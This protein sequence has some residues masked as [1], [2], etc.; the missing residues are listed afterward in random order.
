ML[1]SHA[2]RGHHVRLGAAWEDLRAVH[3]YPPAVEQL[4][5]EA[6]TA[7]VLLAATLKFSGKLTLQF[8]GHGQVSLLVAQC[9]DDFCVR[10]VAQHTDD[11]PPWPT[12]LRWLAMGA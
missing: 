6:V 3:A 4:L 7:V 2:V 1:E 11:V 5:G 9:T 10:A 8:S 12:S